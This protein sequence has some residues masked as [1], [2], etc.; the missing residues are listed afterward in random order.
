MLRFPYPYKKTNLVQSGRL[1][2]KCHACVLTLEP[3]G[4]LCVGW[5]PHTSN[6]KQFFSDYSS[7]NADKPCD[8]DYIFFCFVLTILHEVLS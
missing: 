3:L 4:S 8:S 7:S 2:K 5:N 6:L 1:E